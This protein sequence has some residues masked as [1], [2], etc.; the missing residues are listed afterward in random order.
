MESECLYC[1]TFFYGRSGPIKSGEAMSAIGLQ[2]PCTKKMEFGGWNDWTCVKSI[3]S[4]PAGC[5]KIDR[6]RLQ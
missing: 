6:I 2:S 3:N 5:H 4:L 1:L